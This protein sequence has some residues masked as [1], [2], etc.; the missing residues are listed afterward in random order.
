MAAS[1]GT[2]Q[3]GDA[4]AQLAQQGVAG[5]PVA[6]DERAPTH[7]MHGQHHPAAPGV[8]HRGAPATTLT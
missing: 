4:A 8:G 6:Y 2:G 3:I 5:S 7:D 1:V